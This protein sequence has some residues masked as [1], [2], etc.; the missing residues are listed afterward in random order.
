MVKIITY[1]A[2]QCC[3]EQG[4]LDIVCLLPNETGPCFGYF[5]RYYYN[6][7]SKT[8]EQFIY[9]G[10]QSNGNNFETVEECKKKCPVCIETKILLKSIGRAAVCFT[11][12]LFLAVSPESK[13]SDVAEAFDLPV[14][15]LS[16]PEECTYP[17]DAGPCDAYMKRFFY[18][19]L[20]KSCEE[21]IYGGCGG[22]ANNFRTFTDCDNKCKK[23]IGLIPRS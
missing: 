7:T 6:S 21:F 4:Q 11:R 1:S 3:S 5:P 2:F 22:N 13:S 16:T 9:G 20:T 12:N 8:C 18:N 10:C 19:T 17:A 15:P 14:W 23:I